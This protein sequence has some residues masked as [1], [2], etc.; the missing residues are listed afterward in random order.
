MPVLICCKSKK[1]TTTTGEEPV[2][3][4]DFINYYPKKSLPFTYTDA[5]LKKKESDSAGINLG[6]FNQ[7]VTDSII[8]KFIGKDKKIRLVPVARITSDD[9]GNYLFSKIISGNR[10][11]LYLM[12]FDKQSKYITGIPVLR[13]DQITTTT[14][15]SVSMDKKFT[16]TRTLVRR[17]A[18]GS[19]SEGRDVYGLNEEQTAF[20]LIMTDAL[21]DRATELTNPIDT[22]SKK[23]KFAGDYSSGKLTLVSIRDGRK[24]DLLSFYIHFD[25]DNGACTGELKGEA[26]MRSANSAEYREPGDPCVLKFNFTSNAVN[27]TELEGCGAHRGLRCSFNGRYTR[28]KVS[29]K[30]KS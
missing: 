9:D 5:D 12:W 13:S 25:R 29:T 27:L 19:S 21:D 7:F 6:V 30:P 16:I 17:N 28:K 10:Q 24:P 11:A 22:L 14:A 20:M 8:Y 18:D 26:L 4:E 15:Q 1:K 3:I 23:H 2:K